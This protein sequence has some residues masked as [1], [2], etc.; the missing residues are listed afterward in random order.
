MKKN[1]LASFIVY[2]MMFVIAILVGVFIIRD[3]IMEYGSS[4]RINQ[5]VLVAISVVAGILFNS[6]ILEAGHVIGFKLGKYDVYSFCLLGLTWKRSKDGKI[7]F[8]VGGFDG[9]T[10][11]TKAKPHDVE[12]SNPSQVILMPIVLFFAELL[13]CV[14]MIV[15]ATQMV[16]NGQKDAAWLQIFAIIVLAVGGMILLYNIFPAHLDSTTDGYRMTILSKPINRVAFNQIMLADYYEAVGEPLEETPVYTEI[17]DFTSELN[18]ITVYRQI[19]RGGYKKALSIIDLTYGNRDKVTEITYAEFGAL[20][21]L[22]SILTEGRSAQALYKGMD[23]LVKK[24]VGYLDDVVSVCD[25]ALVSGYLEGSLT[26]ANIALSKAEHVLKKAT[27]THKK[28]YTSLLNETV[29][30]IKGEH[31]EWDLAYKAE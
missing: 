16:N 17:S 22:L 8:S 24:H 9:L 11:E 14:V 1:E 31:P 18:L 25:Y 30:F 23:N 26:E 28:M 21:L 10:G 20:K 5:W 6:F 19:E 15:V 3:T 13:M 27:D 12:T 4:L 29:K 7:A 2:V